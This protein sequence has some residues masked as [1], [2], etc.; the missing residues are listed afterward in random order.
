M[1]ELIQKPQFPMILIKKPGNR[2]PLCVECHEYADFWSKGLPYCNRCYMEK[3]YKPI[4][5]DEQEDFLNL[6]H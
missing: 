2:D 1:R 6:K 4:F 3:F 5:E